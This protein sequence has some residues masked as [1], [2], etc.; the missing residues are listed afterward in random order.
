M[1][2]KFS[3]INNNLS[4]ELPEQLKFVLNDQG[5]IV[6]YKNNIGGA[7]TLFPFSSGAKFFSYTTYAVN[8]GMWMFGYWG[9]D[10]QAFF[11][12]CGNNYTYSI[13]LGD[14]S[15][16]RYNTWAVQATVKVAGKY[17]LCDHGTITTL[18]Y[19]VGDKITTT[20][21]GTARSYICKVG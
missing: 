15:V 20:D 10:I 1:S 4:E 9:E 13:D 8:A 17:C 6:G 5:K 3:Y 7:D 18:D 11:E 21:N 2:L 19:N 14:I 12:D 16:V